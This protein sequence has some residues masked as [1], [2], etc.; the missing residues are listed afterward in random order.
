M[1]LSRDYV[2]EAGS[3]FYDAEFGTVKQRLGSH[4]KDGW[5][6]EYTEPFPVF[7]GE[8]EFKLVDTSG[9]Y[10]RFGMLIITDDLDLT[11]GKTDVEY[12]YFKKHLYK[13]GMYTAQE[14]SN[15]K[16]SNRP[17]TDIAVKLNDEYMNFDVEPV[18]MNGRT[19]VP[20]RAIFEALGCTVSWDAE[21]RIASG[22]RNGSTID[23]TIDDTTAVVDG[24]SVTLDQAATIV[25]GRTLVPLR[26]VSEALSAAVD[27]NGETRTVTILATIPEEI[28]WLRPSSFTSLGTWTFDINA[29]G[30]FDTTAFQGLATGSTID[31]ADASGAKPAIAHF[32]CANDGEYNLWVR[33]RDFSQ[34]QQGHRFFNVSVNGKL[35][36]HKFGTHAGDGY[37]WAKAPEKVT[38]KKGRNEIQLIDSS[39]FYARCDSILVAS[40]DNFVPPE[41]LLSLKAMA[42]P[43]TPASQKIHRFPA[44]ATEQNAP[45]ESATIENNST[46]VVFYKVPTSKGQVVQNEIYAKDASGNWVKTNSR[47]EELGHYIIRADKATSKASADMMTFE[48]EYTDASGASVPYFG[49]NPYLSGKGEWVVPTDFTQN[50]SSVTLSYNDANGA[51]I[52]DVWTLEESNPAPLVSS[53]ITAL[54]DGYYSLGSFEGTDFSYEEFS[55][56][57]AP[58]RVIKKRVHD[59]VCAVSEQFLFTPMG[60]YTLYENNKYSAQ[61][62][63]KGIVP[64]PEY[65]PLRWVYNDNTLISVNMKTPIGTYK[66]TLFAPNMGSPESKLAANQDY[67]VKYRVISSVS[68][69]FE[70]Y[71]FVSQELFDVNDYRQNTYATLND[72]IFNTRKLIL[73]DKYGGWDNNMMGH[74]NMEAITT[75]SDANPMQALQDYLLS[76][77][78]EM[79]ERRAIPTIAAF[80]T[81]SSLHFNPG[82]IGY[83]S[84]TGW[85]RGEKEPDAIGTP[86]AG[87]NLNVTAGLYEMTRGNT[88]ALYDLGLKKGQGSVKNEYGS[89]AP[90]SNN[91]NLYIY[92]GEQKYLDDAIKQADE[93]LEKVV[94]AE[95]SQQLP[96]ESFIYISYYPNIASLMDIYDVTKDKKYLDA[97]EYVAQMML[98][99]LWVPGID[100]DK[101]TEQVV[102]NNIDDAFTGKVKTHT[103]ALDKRDSYNLFWH[104]DHNFRVGDDKLTKE[105]YLDPIRAKQG[106]A[107]NWIHSRVGLG[108]EQASTFDSSSSNIIM[109]YWAGDFVRLSAYTG[110]KAYENAARNAIIGRFSNYPGYY[111]TFNFTLPFYPE[112]PYDGPDFS[113]IYWHHLPPFLAMIE[114]FLISQTMSWS[115][116]NIE[117][118]ALRQQGYAYF[119]SHQYGHKPG[120]FYDQTDM[121]PYL[122]ENTIDSGNLQIDW[123][124]ARKDGMLGIALMNESAEDVTTT[125]SLLDGIPG[126]TAYTGKAT[127]FD[128]AGNKTEIDVTNGKFEITVPAKALKAVTIAIPGIKAPAFAKSNYTLDSKYEIGG[129]VSN[130]ANGK[131]YVIQISPENY[132][133]YVYVT[134]KPAA[135]KEVK[136][137]YTADGKTETISDN[138]YPYEFIVK[139]NDPNSEFVYDITEITTN[140][141][142]VK[143]GGATLMS[144]ALSESK[145]LTYKEPENISAPIT[146]KIPDIAY[147][148]TAGDFAPFKL[149]Y[150]MQGAKTDTNQIRFVVLK[151]KLPIPATAVEL[152][153]LPIKGKL[154]DGKTTI[155]VVSVITGCE[156]RDGDKVV[157]TVDCP[158]NVPL[159]NYMTSEGK[160]YTFDLTI[161]PYNK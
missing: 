148:G 117:F 121:W 122:A 71:K 47:D 111:Q 38:L 127:V 140:N 23:L 12:K 118:P 110:E 52:S 60:C 18:I 65:L 133:A 24:K 43:T 42:S 97:A 73:D 94:Y 141:A 99:A 21:N 136:L 33:S 105:N 74:Y 53:T 128:K 158:S 22:S 66:G 142:E 13:D 86:R 6:W 2:S 58:F 104:G 106:T 76:E 84:T 1:A 49:I 26:F 48:T 91:L 102:I 131:G 160:S 154:V 14:K 143:L 32:D 90:F 8:Y 83:G 112:Y 16:D 68:D 4:G 30:A 123:M 152:A 79:L 41:N 155:E 137:T 17:D 75:V 44:Y 61:P 157:V 27:W 138:E 87:Y 7:S 67:T 103:S 72:A 50:G 107:E 56:A 19:M 92:T 5:F 36:E 57:V 109:Q 82:L 125:V 95:M 81:R 114:E 159:A 25:D 46:K 120:K 31:E 37:K 93:Y 132:F 59:E 34:N 124:A 139:V 89:V 69:W 9:H 29:V 146:S 63:T 45:T 147:N 130:H 15:I 85:E 11:F 98:T 149:E 39:G 129:T 62:I 80:L 35:V 10:A 20:F 64:D 156:E 113:S 96:W 54:N 161:S 145:G 135:V 70:N 100:G 151:S 88:P 40:N 108:I 55:D 150:V 77:D 134:D 3:R 153:G 51:K 101:K 126:G 78:E 116:F 28:Y 119:N 115:D 144:K